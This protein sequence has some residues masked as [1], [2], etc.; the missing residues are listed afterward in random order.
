MAQTITSL[1]G[2]LTAVRDRSIELLGQLDSVLPEEV[3]RAS[4]WAATYPD[5]WSELSEDDRNRANELRSEIR[6][7][8]AGIASE[9]QRSLL[10]DEADLRT[11]GH[12]A[13]RMAAALKLKQ[14]RHWGIHIH[15]DE[16]QYIGM[17]PPGQSEDD[18]IPPMVAK[19]EFL[20]AY[21][22][23]IELKDLLSAKRDRL[24]GFPSPDGAAGLQRAISYKPGT[25]FVMMWINPGRPDLNDVRDV[26]REV[27]AAFD[28]KALRADEIEHSDGI[29]ERII[30]QIR[31]SEYLFA[32]LTGERP[33]VYYEIG[34]AHALGKNV[35]L[36]RKKDT[37]IHFDL[38]YRNCPEYEN[39]GDLRIKL[40]SRLIALTNKNA[41]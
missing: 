8:M 7:I 41:D 16:D 32:D 19:G 21:Q 37:T 22:E 17:D 25:A 40:R 14:Y 38:A 5:A 2:L 35:I 1:Y 27:F 10:V 3:K 31:Q 18:P 33:S 20:S 24:S 34:Y 4:G 29:T 6:R 26:A 39:L 30:E 23:T 15:H 28:I 9:A 36:Y 13:K 11:I 12:N